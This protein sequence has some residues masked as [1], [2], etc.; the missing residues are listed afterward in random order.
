MPSITKRFVDRAPPGRHYDD[1]LP[2][3][4]LYVGK[5]GRRS[6]FVEY[7]TGHGRAFPKRRYTLGVHGAPAPDGSTWTAEK[8]RTEALRLLGKI[9]DG[10]DPLEARRRSDE[11]RRRRRP[12]VADI[13]A[14]WLERDQKRNR[15]VNEVQRLME[16]HV[17]PR[18]GHLE[19]EAITRSD[20]HFVLDKVKETAPVRANRVLAWMRR[21]FRWAVGRDLLP[22]DPTASIAK[23]T[24][25][26]SRDR[27]L[28]DCE[29]S[30]VWHAAAG[31]QFP[32]GMIVR[33]LILTGCRRDE[34]GALRWEEVKDLDGAQPRIE[35]G[36]A[37][38]KTGVARIVPLSGPAV[39]ILR[40]LP[41][42]SG[43]FVF[44][45]GGTGPF[46][47]WS[48]AKRELDS[49]VTALAGAPLPP[50]RLHDLRRTCATGLQRLGVRL[51]VTEA[52]LGHV[53]GSRSGVIGVYQRWG[54]EPEKREAL[55]AWGRHVMTVV[56]SRDADPLDNNQ[57]A[58]VALAE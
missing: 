22:S 30:M 52:V 19:A 45:R 39:D 54:Y 32:Y 55:E 50:W 28:D 43:P 44:G 16:K 3:F 48:R 34:I 14:E 25:E 41:R 18:I 29:L 23:P 35:L 11:E 9:R 13:C 47:G 42:R 26:E 10:F 8:A 27:V 31:M 38:T 5:S 7:R 57:D 6:Y 21:M 20:I 33:L 40:A 56:C 46:K 15:T 1:R 17:L 53:S 58:K 24:R 4:G 36:G 2:G 12:T 37:R 49:R 51:E